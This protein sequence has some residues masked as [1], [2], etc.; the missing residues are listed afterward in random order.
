MVICV[1]DNDGRIININPYGLKLFGYTRDEAVNKTWI[2]L[3]AP[4]D[5]PKAKGII[6]DIKKSTGSKNY[7]IQFITKSDEKIYLLWSTGSLNSKNDEFVSIG[8]DITDS[9]K[10]QENIKYL[11]FYDKLTD[12]PNK[13]LL[14]LEVDKLI[15]RSSPRE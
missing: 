6:N 7:E 15:I 2:E 9:K 3:L 4:E 8:V 1:W 5:R 13:A 11:A 10:Y 12:L 14:E